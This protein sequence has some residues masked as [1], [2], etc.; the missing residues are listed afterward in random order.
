V[1]ATWRIAGLTEKTTRA[2]QDML[3]VLSEARYTNQDGELLAE[4][5]E[6][7]V[8]VALEAGR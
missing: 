3:I 4:N 7:I 5:E 2:G 1:T 6:T 8:F